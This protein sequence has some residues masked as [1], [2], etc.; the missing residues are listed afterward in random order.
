MASVLGDVSRLP[1]SL[2]PLIAEA[3]RRM[4]RRQGLVAVA[5]LLAAGAAAATFA[6]HGS[7][8]PGSGATRIGHSSAAAL[9][10]GRPVMGLTCEK[11]LSVRCNRLGLAVWLKEPAA[12]VTARIGGR[13]VILGT[14][15]GGSGAY[16][17][18]LFWQALF[19]DEHA[20]A[21][22]DLSASIPVRIRVMSRSGRVSKTRVFVNVSEGYG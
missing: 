22:A 15:A 18:G 11:A 7:G 17:R 20:P 2:D 1:F 10:R 4:R 5:V 9:L 12:A 8:G 19:S 3:K 21:W 13:A 14:K 16:S 6:L